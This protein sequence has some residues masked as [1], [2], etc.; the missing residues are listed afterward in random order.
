CAERKAAE[1][2]Q[3]AKA[4]N[5]KAQAEAS[6]KSAE[7]KAKALQERS[8]AL[9]S[10][11]FS[12]ARSGDAQKVKKSVYEDHVDAAGGEVKRG[13]DAYMT[14][15]PKDPSETLSHI[16]ANYGDVD[17][18]QWLDTHG[19]DMEERNEAGYTPFHVALQRGYTTVL[20]Y[21]FDMH[22][23]DDSEAIYKAPPSKSLLTLAVESAQPEVVWMILDKKLASTKDMTDAWAYITSDGRKATLNKLG[24]AEPSDKAEE[25][26]NLLATFGGFTKEADLEPEAELVTTPQSIGRVFTSSPPLL[27]GSGSPPPA[28]SSQN[29]ASP[30]KNYRN[31]NR[32]SAP[33]ST[34]SQAS[35]I[36]L[37]S[38]RPASASGQETPPKSAADNP[39]ANTEHND[40]PAPP[41][42]R[43]RGYGR[44]RGRERG[45]KGRGRGGRP[46]PV[47]S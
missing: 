27:A 22:E 8:Q 13:C 33:P 25:I 24:L 34:P 2:R 31:Y 19:A 20:K 12:A 36:Q 47:S 9:R 40:Q 18:L 21:F 30:K 16:A 10:A 42:G 32:K 14:T 28:L 38:L 26:V 4:S 17:L 44:G 43:G 35:P 23:P 15:S 5:K 1:T 7:S 37:E 29:G 45:F 46:P 6:R 39:T 41:R 3:K 11:V